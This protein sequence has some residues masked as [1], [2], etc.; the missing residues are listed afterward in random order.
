MTLLRR[1]DP[2]VAEGS[3]LHC[4]ALFARDAC[5]SE[6]PSEALKTVLGSRAVECAQRA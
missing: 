3:G 5:A 2:D 1:Q 4:F 6:R